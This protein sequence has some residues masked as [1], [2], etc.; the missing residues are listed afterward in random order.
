MPSNPSFEKKQVVF[1]SHTTIGEEPYGKE[2]SDKNKEL[3]LNKAVIL[4]KDVCETDKYGRLLRYVYVGDVFINAE[5][6]MLGYAQVT[7]YPP[8]VKYQS[9]FLQLQREAEEAGR[10]LWGQDDS[11]IGRNYSNRNK[12][13]LIWLNGIKFTNV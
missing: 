12:G 2:A 11:E 4:E 3:V 5:L 7:T 13:E 10:G 9:L 6:V 8:D 1:L